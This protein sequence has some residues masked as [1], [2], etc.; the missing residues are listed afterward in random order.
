MSG[1][2]RFAYV[3]C[4]LLLALLVG[5]FIFTGTQVEPVELEE[6]AKAL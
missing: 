6:V 5:Y 3:L 4:G 2:R 1:G